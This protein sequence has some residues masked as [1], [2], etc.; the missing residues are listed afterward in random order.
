VF[1]GVFLMRPELVDRWELRI[2]VSTE[3]EET[4]RRAV[5]REAFAAPAAAVERRWR[6]RYLPAQEL[7]VAAARPT[8]RADVL[9]RNDDPQRPTWVFCSVDGPPVRD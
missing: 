4:I 7:Y 9:V 8:E 1:D 6:E 3:P 5:S 2:L